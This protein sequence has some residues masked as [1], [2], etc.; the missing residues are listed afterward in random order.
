MWVP[1]RLAAWRL[2]LASEACV[3]HGADSIGARVPGREGER[4]RGG[5]VRRD[6]IVLPPPPTAMLGEWT[7]LRLTRTSHRSPYP[8]GA[9]TG[10]AR[11]DTSVRLSLL[12]SEFQ[13]PG[14]FSADGQAV[15]RT[16]ETSSATVET[17]P[18]KTPLAQTRACT[19]SPGRLC[20]A[21]GR[22]SC[23]ID[24]PPST[25]PGG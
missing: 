24:M 23:R 13:G 1:P 11:A 18:K 20:R 9:A 10:T 4:G 12:S 7:S 22:T 14:A 25:S 15:L 2:G 21:D 5:K 19:V 8:I 3:S 17:S 16:R 6:A